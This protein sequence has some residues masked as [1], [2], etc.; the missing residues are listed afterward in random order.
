MS[1]SGGVE[2]LNPEIAEVSLARLAIPIGPVLA[3]HRRVFGVAE[4]F[5]SASAIAFGFRNDAFASRPAGRGIGGSWHFCLPRGV[6]APLF[7]EL[8]VPFIRAARPHSLIAPG[9][10]R[11]GAQ[12]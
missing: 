7:S 3:L 4:K 2:S 8:F 10:G 5:R 6:G 11:T 12:I 1:A 9:C